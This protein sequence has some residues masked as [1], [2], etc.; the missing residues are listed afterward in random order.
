MSAIGILTAMTCNPASRIEVETVHIMRTEPRHSPLPAILLGIFVP[1]W[2]ALAISPVSRQDWL[3]EN[4]LVLV[5]V[6]T[7]VLTAQRL[8][9]SNGVY[10]C[11]FF[12]LVL[13]SIG[14][15]YTYALVPYDSGWQSL[16]GSTFNELFGWQR[17]HYDRLVH[18]LYGVLILPAAMELF[19][20]YTPLS[21]IWRWLIPFFFVAS[22]GGIY[23][24]VEWIAALIVAPDLG[25][26]YL[27]TQGDPWDAQ[28][29]MAWATAGA[30]L[31]V[32]I[33][34]VKA[35]LTTTHCR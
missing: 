12:F 22:H 7:L 13:H 28:W 8:R 31:S 10:L 26:A 27:G 2:L 23:E 34:R 32:L 15:H 1:I 3:L 16:T 30:A 6:P 17:N 33:L 25:N 14:A 4:L 35:K 29:D 24:I 18:F 5:A 20:R 21:G 11:L 19:E 9:F